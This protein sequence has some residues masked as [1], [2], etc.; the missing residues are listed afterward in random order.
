MDKRLM[1]DKIK[2]AWQL[3]RRLSGD[4]AYEEYLKH[5]TSCHMNCDQHNQELLDKKTYFKQR[6]EEK[7]NSMKRCC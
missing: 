3:V 2:L 6:L 1:I 5:F 7:W 4:D